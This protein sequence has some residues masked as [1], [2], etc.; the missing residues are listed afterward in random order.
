MTLAPIP[1][2]NFAAD[3]H[4]AEL[5]SELPHLVF[6]VAGLPYACPIAAVRQLLLLANAEIIRNANPERAWELGCLPA[7]SGGDVG[8]KVISLRNFWGL[9][10]L[11]GPAQARQALLTLQGAA[12]SGAFIVDGCR[13]VLPRLPVLAGQFQIPRPLQVSHGD[14]FQAAVPW[15]RSLLITVNLLSLLNSPALP[16]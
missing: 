9:P 3:A 2:A 16:G 12:Q 6:E 4:A 7:R 14:L 13:C 5:A 1:L 8:I 10:E 11:T 15:N